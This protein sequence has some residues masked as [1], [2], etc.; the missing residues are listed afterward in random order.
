[1]ASLLDDENIQHQVLL[2]ICSG[3]GNYAMGTEDLDL[4]DFK[5][6][7]D[8]KQAG[9]YVLGSETLECLKDLKKLLKMDI[10][11]SSSSGGGGMFKKLGTWNIVKKHLVPLFL[12]HAVGKYVPATEKP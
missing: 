7:I 1:M 5:K 9:E 2:S 3:L 4:N 6:Q 10:S 12:H 11:S 8:C